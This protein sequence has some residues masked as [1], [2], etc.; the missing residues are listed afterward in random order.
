MTE[1]M[2][3]SDKMDTHRLYKQNIVQIAIVVKDVEQTAKR[4]WELMGVG[5]WIFASVKDPNVT[6]IVINDKPVGDIEHHS[7]V[8]VA[9]F[10]NIQFE[11]IQPISGQGSHQ[12]FL[13]NHGEGVHHISFGASD[14][15]DEIVA[16]LKQKGIRIEMSGK[17]WRSRQFTYMA[18]QKDLGVRF[19]W[20]K[21][22]P[23]TKPGEGIE[24]LGTYPPQE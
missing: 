22:K 16:D 11:L 4:Y 9:D 18:T 21:L 19:E 6:D 2:R 7:K 17:I 24:I 3:D 15:H 23:G 1:I 10:N 20:L 5:P 13:K 8:A 12:D 14:D